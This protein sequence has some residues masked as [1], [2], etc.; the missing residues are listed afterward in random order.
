MKKTDLKNEIV[1]NLEFARDSYTLNGDFLAPMFI[2]HTTEK[3]KIKK[4]PFLCTDTEERHKFSFMLGVSHGILLFK[5]EIDSIN[6]I[7]AVF[8]A[9]Y[10]TPSKEDNKNKEFLRPSLDPNR[11]EAIVSGGQIKD[12]TNDIAMFE[13]KK[14]FKGEKVEVE[15]RAIEQI[16]K[17]VKKKD[18]KES[19]SPLL[20]TFWKGVELVDKLFKNAPKSIFDDSKIVS[21]EE[22]FKI[23]ERD[24]K[25]Y[26]Y[27]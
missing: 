18:K 8:E 17:E 6:A 12:G 10:S 24:L 16:N 19:E 5:K 3:G 23:I 13:L 2:V 26:N 14:S 7:F 25:K 20:N 21:S 11:K 1:N 9:W 22:I 15:F 4:V 27:L